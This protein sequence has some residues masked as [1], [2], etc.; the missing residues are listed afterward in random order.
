MKKSLLSLFFISSASY[1]YVDFVIENDSDIELIESYNSEYVND[2]LK[3]SGNVVI[4]YGDKK[5]KSDYITINLKERNIKAS[6][7]IKIED[8]NGNVVTAD[9][10]RIKNGF[11]DGFLDKIHIVL[12]DKSYMKADNASF[13]GKDFYEMDDVEYS[14]CYQCVMNDKLTWKIKAKKIEQKDNEI[15]FKN[16]TMEMLDV[17]VMWLPYLT[18]PGVGVKRKTGF[19]YPL[20]SHS[21]ISGFNICPR[22]LYSISD[23]QELL[24]KPVITTKIGNVFWSSYAHRFYSG[25]FTVDASITGIKSVKNIDT[26]DISNPDQ[27]ELKKINNNN[28]RGHIFSKYVYELDNKN[29]I[30]AQ[31]NLVSDKYYLRKIPFLINEELRL[32]E[33]NICAEHFDK[34]NYTSIKTMYFQTLR[35]EEKTS[36]IPLAIPV[37][38]H[39][40]TY[41]MLYGKLNIDALFMHLNFANNHTTDK[42]F[43]N[44]SWKKDFLFKYGHTVSLNL[45]LS[46]SFN[47]IFYTNDNIKHAHNQESSLTDISPMVG[48][49]WKW[50]LEVRYKN[51][52]IYGVIRPVVGVIC[53]PNRKLNAV[54]N[55]P[56]TSMQF[57]ELNDLNFLEVIRSPFSLQ[58]NDGTR[59]P[60]GVIGEIYKS[61]NQIANFSIGR[62]Y[63]VSD[64]RNNI[65]DIRHKYSSII[66]NAN[67]FVGNNTTVF[68]NNSYSTYD[69]EFKR[70]EVGVRYDGNY[71]NLKSSAFRYLQER[72]RSTNEG[73]HTLE[74]KFKG[75]KMSVE[76]KITRRTSL[77]GELIAGGP[78]CRLLRK[79]FGVRYQNEC[80]S[81]NVVYSQHSFKSGDIKPDRSI[82][83]LVIFKNLGKMDFKV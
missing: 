21:K 33:S 27:D 60:H 47:S 25:E 15:T 41:D 31:L 19:L 30:S 48:V 61:G 46:S 23:S 54:Y 10:V 1:A 9:N 56:Y 64:I 45:V 2:D 50:P 14:P 62:S 68:T 83:I 13:F 3:L 59:I 81:A 18:I 76:A 20:L 12:N 66:S 69:H 32:L 5:I 78:S 72:I 57:F 24:I 75:L 16:A 34:D 63:N 80:F 26:K 35:A 40:S 11:K 38:T 49:I 65:A 82:S 6:G 42:V 29:K 67:I 77:T 17:P 8:V 43:A 51:S 44:A 58:I 7:N 22:F 71:I 79:S 74:D 73:Q 53:S 39:S 55:D 36:D 37:I 70:I 4:K 52:D 28:Y